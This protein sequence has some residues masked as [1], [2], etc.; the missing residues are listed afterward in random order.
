MIVEQLNKS[1]EHLRESR[2]AILVKGGN[3]NESA[4]LKDLPNA[5]YGL[6]VGDASITEVV[7]DSIGNYKA[8]LS[9]AK[10][11]ALLNSF[12]G[13][14]YRKVGDNLFN[15]PAEGID[16]VLG[17][18]AGIVAGYVTL[19]AGTYT[20]RL[21]DPA[22][23]KEITDD[24]PIPFQGLY[25]ATE[26]DPE[27]HTKLEKTFTLSAETTVYFIAYYLGSHDYI[28]PMRVQVMLNKGS[29]QL[30][31]APFTQYLE[32]TK[33]TEIISHGANLLDTSKYILSHSD[34]LSAEI[35][36]GRIALTLKRNITGTSSF[37]N[38]KYELRIPDG[39]TRI[40]LKGAV[41]LSVT[42]TR[43]LTVE[44]YDLNKNHIKS[45]GL[46]FTNNVTG[47][48]EF[49][50]STNIPTGTVYAY[51]IYYGIAGNAAEKGFTVEW[52]NLIV[53][54]IDI[55]YTPYRDPIRYP[56]PEAIQALSG[57]GV[58]HSYNPYGEIR[59]YPNYF[60]V[61]DKDKIKFYLQSYRATLNGTEAW[62]MTEAGK[63]R[64]NRSAINN[65]VNSVFIHAEAANRYNALD[66]YQDYLDGKEG[67]Y[68]ASSSALYIHDYRFTT[69]EDF[70]AYLAR[71]PLEIIYT[72]DKVVETDLAAEFDKI[73]EVEG[74]G[75]LEFVNEQQNAVPSKITYIRSIE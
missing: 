54:V 55:P 51:V 37:S 68:A 65:V 38:A 69:L 28:P 66:Q 12:G 27:N 70:K 46:F 60:E 19:E 7:D 18:N 13:M 58:G 29:T 8:I 16:I 57:Y 67:I 49:N 71:E 63:F 41:N 3:I 20:Y 39:Y 73:I 48:Y 33:V 26:G 43:R 2:Q 36:E 47:L 9:G 59:S 52:S 74:G 45:S 10:P 25:F 5:I 22:E 35:S 17:D 32:D 61:I 31:F 4:G 53:S 40:Y 21:Y 64:I 11:K 14:T 44:F 62:T 24:D 56:I 75:Y 30:P 15:C 42:G 6:P 1:I 34:T 23:A 72:I 50:T